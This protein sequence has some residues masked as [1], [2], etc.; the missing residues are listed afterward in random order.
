MPATQKRFDIVTIVYEAELEALKVQ[1]RSLRKFLTPESVDHYYIA[2]NESKKTDFAFRVES[3]VSS[4]LC[5][6][7]F[8]FE[9][10]DGSRFFPLDRSHGWWSQQAL[11]LLV[12]AQC[13]DLVVILDAKNHFIRECSLE[14]FFAAEC[15]KP[16]VLLRSNDDHL[17]LYFRNAFEY[18]ELNPE[19][20]IHSSIPPVTPFPLRADSVRGL[21]HA[22][23]KKEQISFSG[24]FLQPPHGYTEFFLFQA[25]Q[26]QLHQKF[27]CFSAKSH[28]NVVTFFE[29][30]I[31]SQTK[32]DGEFHA[33]MTRS[34]I[35]CLGL[36]RAALAKM[37]CA[38]KE[39]IANLW[40]TIGLFADSDTSTV[41]LDALI[42]ASSL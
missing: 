35:V 30:K 20:Y 6:T 18:F 27:E 14:T 39:K 15:L 38:Q 4:I 23:E 7:G 26:I 2:L 28:R 13:R 10:I 21:I 12:A 9:V 25:Y 37:N 34:E 5:D 11:K 19:I 33:A 22:I 41:A 32:F 16:K 17:G 42:T 3:E 31:I 36:H 24:F 1:A 40:S 8:T 29:D